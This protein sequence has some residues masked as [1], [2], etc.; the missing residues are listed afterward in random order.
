MECLFQRNSDSSNNSNSYT[1]K[2]SGA[3]IAT[4]Q[5][6]THVIAYDVD[7]TEREARERVLEQL[8]RASP[9]QDIESLDYPINKLR[10]PSRQESVQEEDEEEQVGV[11]ILF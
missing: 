3:D 8:K 10:L 4:E 7:A 6:Q 1:T 11:I 2:P 5:S 9:S